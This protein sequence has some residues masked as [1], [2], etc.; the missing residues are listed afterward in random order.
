[1][2]TIDR[3]GYVWKKGKSLVPA[4]RAFAVVN[5]LEFYFAELVDYQFTAEMESQLDEI[6][7][8]RQDLE[9]WLQRFYF[10]D[11]SATSELA[12]LGLEHMTHVQH[13]FDFAAIN[14][15]ILGTA[16]DGL[17]VSVRSGRYGPYLIHGD[18]RASI[19]EATEPDSLTVEHAL[20]LLAAP[21]N[22]RELGLDEASG[23]TIY[24]KAGRYGPYVQIGELTDPKNKPHT[25][26]LFSTMSPET[27][28]LE[29]ARKLLSLPR[30]VGLHPENQEPVMAQ[31]GRYG[32]YLTWG[33]ETRSLED[34]DHI[35]KVTLEEALALYAQPKTRGR[36]AAAGPLREL[37]E[38]PVTKKNIVVRN[39]RFGLYVSDGEVN[40]TLRLG[41]LP[42]TISLDRACELL[43]ERRNAEPSTR[44]RK[45]VKKAT[46]KA[47]TKK[48]A[49][50]P[51]KAAGAT[52]KATGAQKRAAVKQGA[53]ANAALASIAQHADEE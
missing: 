51:T 13:E 27:L 6:A 40:A 52:K 33:K 46:K 9:P 32:P 48:T 17:P 12:R 35:F 22:D 20:E 14:S 1:M 11:P 50:K 36:R 53:S 44:P 30:E 19:P 39:G 49:K 34:E 4:Y 31:N 16:P 41:D 25:A 21:S 42:E 28:T 18:D 7:E 29:D 23:E 15:I 8:G 10:G 43:A 3:R 47:A 37:G 2:K 45:A 38:D 26:S 24:L 5:L